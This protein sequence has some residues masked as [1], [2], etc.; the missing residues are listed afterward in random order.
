MSKML[1]QEQFED[2]K[3]KAENCM[4]E[5]KFAEAFF[6][7]TKAIH[8]AVAGKTNSGGGPEVESKMY[9]Q[10]AKCLLQSDQ[11]YYALEDAKKV[12]DLDPQNAMGHLRLAE[13]Y[14]ETGHFME[15]LPVIGKCFQISTGKSEKDYLLEWQRKCRRDAAKQKIKV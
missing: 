14:Y 11:Y 2:V 4:K 3:S 13:V 15:A 10:R 5:E 7:W 12:L 9:A 6:H 1:L 8:L